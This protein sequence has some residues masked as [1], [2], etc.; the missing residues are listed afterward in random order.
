M[1]RQAMTRDGKTRG[2]QQGGGQAVEE[3]VHG[4]Q[5]RNTAAEAEEGA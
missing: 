3:C 1:E 2:G 4:E 5:G